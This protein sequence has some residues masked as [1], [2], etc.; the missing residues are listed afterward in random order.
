MSEQHTPGA[1]KD[2][3]QAS[4]AL[5][6]LKLRGAI[7]DIAINEG[8]LKIREGQLQV[9]VARYTSE[10]QN[11][12]DAALAAKA[13]QQLDTLKPQLASVKEELARLEAEKATLTQQQQAILEKLKLSS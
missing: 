9:W 13:Q 2:G 6:L 5:E 11:T 12:S 3:T 8:R 4:A 10:A 7:S 1:G